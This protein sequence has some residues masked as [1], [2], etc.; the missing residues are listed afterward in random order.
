ME[1]T[2]NIRKKLFKSDNRSLKASI[3][4]LKVIKSKLDKET[5]K[6]TPT[7]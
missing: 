3:K 5:K 2:V 6:Q 1:K 4:N 7:K